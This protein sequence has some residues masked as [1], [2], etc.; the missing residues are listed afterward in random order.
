MS[1]LA[2]IQ[3]R[4][5]QLS[6][7]FDVLPHPPTNSL[8]QTAICLNIDPACIARTVPLKDQKGTLLAVLPIS[9]ILDFKLLNQALGR[10]LHLA[11]KEELESE[12]QSYDKDLIP[13]L[14]NI[15]DV[16]MIFDES[17][18]HNKELFFEAGN[19]D[20]FI[21]IAADNYKGL[22]AETSMLKFAHSISGLSDF[23]ATDISYSP[24]VAIRKR[25][26]ELTTVPALPPI[27][28]RLLDLK[29]RPDASV[30]ELAEVVQLD[31]F[32]AAQVIRYA[33]S[34]LYAY[35]GKIDSIED[36]IS[37]VLGFDLV[38]NMAL[39]AGL[40]RSFNHRETGPLNTGAFWKHAV[41]CAA[42][43]QK[44]LQLYANRNQTVSRGM[45]YLCGL[46]HNFGF[47]IM[48]ML[49]KDEF[50]LLNQLIKV[51]TSRPL[52][53]QERT[54]LGNRQDENE[55]VMNHTEIGK[56]IM[57]NWNMPEELITVV[58]NH[59]VQDYQGQFQEYVHLVRIANV[60][61]KSIDVGDESTT[62]LPVESLSLL[63]L[64]RNN[65][66]TVFELFVSD[67]VPDLSAIAESLSA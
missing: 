54:V 40:G 46:L 16:E 64:D 42:L 14:Y 48:G 44:L 56:W 49:F 22:L 50:K 51:N 37:R 33:R 53:E 62:E 60:L 35:R 59:H 41:Y 25:I 57:Q 65:V 66:E 17:L 29:N 63:Q 19:H 13:P 30:T 32:L 28:N 23:N 2:D 7:H 39:G 8:E 20:S 47:L 34:S 21:R 52:I 27:A 24:Y 43:S 1:L 45:I 5:R 38:I 4:L 26:D 58:A 15:A 55:P 11:R 67:D 6:V 36:A 10:D 61:L 12:L 3:P 18:L 9:C 31:P